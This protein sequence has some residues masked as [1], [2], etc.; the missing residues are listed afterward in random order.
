MS[1]P[2]PGPRSR[3]RSPAGG[4]VAAAAGAA[5]L[6]L[7]SACG[8]ADGEPTD[9]TVEPGATAREVGE[10]LARAGLVEH[11]AAF[12]LYARLSGAGTG[13]KSGHYRFRTD[14]TW[15]EML[16]AIR[17]GRVVTHPLS[18]P[19]GSDARQ[20]ARKVADIS[21]VP[22]DSVLSLV[23]DTALARELGVPGPTLEGYL[24]PET[25]RFA[26]DVP[27]R[28]ALSAMV[29][30][31]RAFWGPE[32]RARADSLGMSEREVVTLASIVEREA[33]VPGE[34]AI[35]AGVYVNRLDR[36]MRLQADPTVQY[37]LESPK[38]R[39]LYRDIDSVSGSPYNTYTHAGLPPG[40][41]ASPAAASLRAA[42]APADVPYLYFVA[43]PDG[44][45]V[46]SRTHEEHLA[47]KNRVREP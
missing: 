34:R 13:L 36:G 17:S 16:D 1:A 8:P 18:V 5:A 9:V 35:I 7:L 14:A 28:E 45:H 2:T 25:Y 26:R 24:F 20:V 6:L 3:S 41:I 47:A 44:S 11:P 23:R 33:R 10:R 42:L 39:L 37:L 22:A 27:P 12:T 32:E 21:G 4:S 43:R 19:P 38:E 40:P 30:R 46:F 29:R 15:S 31:Y